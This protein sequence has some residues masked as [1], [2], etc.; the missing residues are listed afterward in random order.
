MGA[1]AT[2][3]DY[4]DANVPATLRLLWRWRWWSLYVAWSA[5]LLITVV[6]DLGDLGWLLCMAVCP[7]LATWLE[8]RAQRQARCSSGDV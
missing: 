2:T 1:K 3:S 5:M 4:N 7:A 8:R 6:H